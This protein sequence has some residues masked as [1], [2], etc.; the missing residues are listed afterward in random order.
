MYRRSSH[1]GDSRS[2]VHWPEYERMDTAFWRES[3]WATQQIIWG[4]A[5]YYRGHGENFSSD[6]VSSSEFS[7]MLYRMAHGGSH[8]K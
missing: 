3:L 6:T 2:R 7:V 5:E 1:T 4:Y 8:L